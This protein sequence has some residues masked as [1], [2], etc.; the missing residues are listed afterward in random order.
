MYLW[1]CIARP[2]KF[3]FVEL[4]QAKYTTDTV[5]IQPSFMRADSSGHVRHRYILC[6]A[7]WWLKTPKP[8]VIQRHLHP[9]HQPP[10]KGSRL[11]SGSTTIGLWPV[12]SKCPLSMMIYKESGA[13]RSSP[14]A[15]ASF[16]P[17]G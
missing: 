5:N 11:P 15:P 2:Y 1:K 10:T 14:D 3:D 6:A 13:P 17:A 9:I 12:V 7:Y 16:P 8:S 4:I